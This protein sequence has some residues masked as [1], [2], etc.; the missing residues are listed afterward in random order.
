MQGTAREGNKHPHHAFTGSVA[1]V[2]QCNEVYPRCRQCERVGI[3]CSFASP[4]LTATPLNADSLAD[5]ELLD[6]W[7]RSPV[8][9]ELSDTA[10][11]LHS[12]LVRLG[13][14]HHYLLNS[15]LGLTALQ[16]FSEDRSQI[17][18]YARAVAHQQTAIARARPHFQSLDDTAHQAVLGFSAFM[19]MYAVAEPLLRPHPGLRTLLAGPFDPIEEL[20]QA[21]R[22]SRCTTRF[23]RQHFSEAS[24]SQSWL[25]II[26]EI[27]GQTKDL[28]DVEKSFPHVRP[29]LACVKRLP[30]G[31]HRVACISAVLQLYNRM[32]E[33]RSR[34]THPERA[35]VIWGWG[36][37]VDEIFLDMCS[38]RHAVAIAVLAHFSVLM[39]FYQEHWCLSGWP[40]GLLSHIR[41]ITGGDCKRAIQWPCDMVFGSGITAVSSAATT[42]TSLASSSNYRGV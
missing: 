9:G 26:P 41:G 40:A 29:L 30:R 42:L 27:H 1:D 2:S 24:I 37:E 3:A 38:A 33:L 32:A 39:T 7:Y 14:S 25:L 11:S 34:P 13:F 17:K 18:W 6:H 28:G 22:F 15:I 4:S 8:M 12:D 36:L 35:K 23:V 31:S 19:S 21:L 10:R 20:L 5:L 16:L